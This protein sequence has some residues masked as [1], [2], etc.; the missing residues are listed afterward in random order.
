MDRY[1]EISLAIKKVKAILSVNVLSNQ[2]TFLVQ[3]RVYLAPLIL[4][5]KK[6]MQAQHKQS[7]RTNLHS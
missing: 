5:V 2:F 6:G 3:I 1:P 7:G 4:L